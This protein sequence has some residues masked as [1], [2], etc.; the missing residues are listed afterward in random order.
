MLAD[1]VQLP[2]TEERTFIERRLY[3]GIGDS[4]GNIKFHESDMLGAMKEG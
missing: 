1:V 4:G 3:D 2:T